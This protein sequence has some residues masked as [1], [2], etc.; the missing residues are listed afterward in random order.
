MAPE[1]VPIGRIVGA[2][3]LKGEL[4]VR[5]FEPRP[6]EMVISVRV[7]G[8]PLQASEGG[9]TSVDPSKLSL[10]E[11]EGLVRWRLT[12][13]SGESKTLSYQY[14]RYVTSN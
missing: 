14:E 13:K 6:V 3:G 8:K 2:H 12:L 7:P 1:F 4:K 11:R 5:N 10:R 9:A